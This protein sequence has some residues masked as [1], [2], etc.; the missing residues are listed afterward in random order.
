MS[1]AI[2]ESIL[3]HNKV[4][5]SVLEQLKEVN[6]KYACVNPADVRNRYDTMH[7]IIETKIT[8]INERKDYIKKCI[9][10][11]EECKKPIA[12]MEK[13]LKEIGETSN[14]GRVGTLFGLCKQ[15][16]KE[17]EISMDEI[18]Q[19]VSDF[20]Y[21]EQ[22]EIKNYNKQNDIIRC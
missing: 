18:E 3:N 22:N 1:A 4:L 8:E 16:I 15:T 7:G 21:D 11:L 19:M 17:N 6:S 9:N 5:V 12:E 2:E 10:D 20:P 13:V 14:K